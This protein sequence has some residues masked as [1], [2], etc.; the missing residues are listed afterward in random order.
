VTPAAE[1]IERL[2]KEYDAAKARLCAG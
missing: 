1:L 2:A